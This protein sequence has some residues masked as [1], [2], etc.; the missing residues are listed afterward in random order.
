M[1]SRRCGAGVGA[2][3]GDADLVVLQIGR[4]APDGALAP[5]P[6][7]AAAPLHWVVLCI[8]CRLPGFVVQPISRRVGAHLRRPGSPVGAVVPCPLIGM[9]SVNENRCGRVSWSLIDCF[10]HGCVRDAATPARG[11]VLCIGVRECMQPRAGDRTGYGG[12]L[13]TA[14]KR[15]GWTGHCG[16][17]VGVGRQSTL[18]DQPGARSGGRCAARAAQAR[19]GRG[20][21]GGPPLGVEESAPIAS[22]S[23][24]LRHSLIR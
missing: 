3:I 17:A 24:R 6:E 20:V 1:A 10:R 11:P 9:V 16:H 13:P 14:R 8:C 23:T 12:A 7:L 19:A 15:V 21:P 18:T 4:S 5:Q 22:R 2:V